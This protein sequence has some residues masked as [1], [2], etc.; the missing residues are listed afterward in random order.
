MDVGDDEFEVY[1]FDTCE[2][3]RKVSTIN[4]SKQVYRD[5][6]VVVND[7]TDLCIVDP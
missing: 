3:A 4:G 6:S 1:G 2:S 5:E 7:I